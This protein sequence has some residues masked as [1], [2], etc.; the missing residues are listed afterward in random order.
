MNLRNFGLKSLYEI[1]EVFKSVSEDY[2]DE[3]LILESRIRSIIDAA[4]LSLFK[5]DNVVTTYFSSMFP[6]SQEL[7]NAI[8]DDEIELLK[9]HANLSKEQN[10]EFRRMIEDFVSEVADRLTHCEFNNEIVYE[11]Y[12]NR[13]EVISAKREHFTYSE[14]AE[15]F[16]SPLVNNFIKSVFEKER[17]GHL[18]VRANNLLNQTPSAY[19]SLLKLIDKPLED[20]SSLCPGKYNKKTLSEIFS[21]NKRFK[22]L[23][24]SYSV[25]DEEQVTNE[26]LKQEYPFL[27]GVQRKFVKEFND[28]Y[29]YKPLFFLLYNYM[30]VSEGRADKMFSLRYGLF[31][32]KTRTLKELDKIVGL[33]PE[34]VRQLSDVW[35]LDVHKTNLISKKIL[36]HY[37]SILDLPFI[38]EHSQQYLE[39]IERE[40]LNVKFPAF[41]LLIQITGKFGIIEENGIFVALNKNYEKVLRIPNSI[42]LLKRLAS[43]KYSSDTLIPIDRVL[44]SLEEPAHLIARKVMLYIAQNAM[45]L[46]LNEKGELL[47]SQNYIDVKKEL[48]DFLLQRGVPMSIE[49]LFL[50]FKT[51]YPGYKY[52]EANQLRASLINNP[53]IKPLGKSSRYGLASWKHVYYGNI[54]DLMAYL[55]ESSDEP[56][57]IEEI[58][59]SVIEHFPKTSIKNITSSMWSDTYNRFVK[60]SDGFYGLSNKQYPEKFYKLDTERQRFSFDER[61]KMFRNFVQEYHRFPIFNGADEEASLRRWLYNVQNGVVEMTR[62]QKIVM[63]NVLKTYE[64]SLIPRNASESAFR[65]NCMDYVSYIKRSHKQPTSTEAAELYRWYKNQSTNTIAT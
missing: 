36:E 21:F 50:A 41:A 29:G 63:D 17:I 4:Y 65:N 53:L 22:E 59:N 60:F 19:I 39:L 30:R 1:K 12:K 9:V 44:C 13:L 61:L 32:G 23:F 57:H 40:H 48:Y 54:R 11:K 24:L 38:T 56:L 64:D 27:I 10:V 26:L 15:L 49:E 47:F 34:R 58:F 25:M 6:S 52:K 16:L 14:V 18:S 7:H 55:L 45:G 62:E 37:Q 42:M 31:D 33:T 5:A 3:E 43:S 35:N 20:Y 8:M 51:K 2:E 46:Y 28:K